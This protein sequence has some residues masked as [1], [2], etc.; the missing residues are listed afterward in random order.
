MTTDPNI[1]VAPISHT[2]AEAQGVPGNAA[3]NAPTASAAQAGG[4]TAGAM[5]PMRKAYRTLTADEQRIVNEFKDLGTIFVSKID[6]LA[7]SRELALAKTKIEEA[8][9]WAVKHVTG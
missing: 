6:N 5:D 1:L 3:G 4:N 8:V 2:G 7:M 9:M